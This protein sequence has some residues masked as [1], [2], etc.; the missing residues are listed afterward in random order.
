MRWRLSSTFYRLSYRIK[1]FPEVIVVSG[2]GAGTTTLIRHV[3][4]YRSVNRDDDLDG[5]KHSPSPSSAASRA[6]SKVVY[7]RASPERQIK[8]LARRGTLRFQ[9]V[10]IGGFR[11]FFPPTEAI[12]EFLAQAIHSQE[13]EYTKKLRGQ[14]LVVSFPDFLND[15]SDL[16]QFLGL[17][18]TDFKATMPGYRA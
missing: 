5:L 2:G 12:E 1:G 18:G 4:K 15:P 9:S 8:S 10:K 17:R 3:S 16:E 7:V 13:A 11:G 14:I 6:L